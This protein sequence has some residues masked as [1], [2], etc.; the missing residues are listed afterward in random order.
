MG[1]I[2]VACSIHVLIG[3]ENGE[4]YDGIQQRSHRWRVKRSPRKRT[5][6]E[7]SPP[8]RRNN[9]LGIDP[10]NACV[11]FLGAPRGL[12]MQELTTSETKERQRYALCIS[13]RVVMRQRSKIETK[14]FIMSLPP[15]ILSIIIHFLQ[16]VKGSTFYIPRGKHVVPVDIQEPGHKCNADLCNSTLWKM[17]KQWQKGVD[18][19]VLLSK[20]TEDQIT[21]NLRKRYSPRL[22][23][24]TDLFLIKKYVEKE[25]NRISCT[26]TLARPSLPSIRTRSFRT[27]PKRKSSSTTEVY[28]LCLLRIMQIGDSFDIIYMY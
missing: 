4:S 2:V 11:L 22:V 1:N 25:F 14:E 6:S 5:S 27:L 20:V 18:D 24:Y 19:M 26:R 28:A 7:S 21:D 8:F 17:L 3:H 10:I 23:E 12:W 15:L 16:G 9:L 13:G